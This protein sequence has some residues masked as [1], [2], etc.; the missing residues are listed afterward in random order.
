MEE[1]TIYKY[2]ATKMALMMY[3]QFYSE[4]MTALENTIKNLKGALLFTQKDTLY[5]EG[6]I[7][8]IK[9][10]C[11]R[12]EKEY[13]LAKQDIEYDMKQY[14][15]CV[16]N[17]KYEHIKFSVFEDMKKKEDLAVDMCF[18]NKKYMG[19]REYEKVLRA[20]RSIVLLLDSIAREAFNLGV[21]FRKT[22]DCSELNGN[23][24]ANVFFEE[25]EKIREKLPPFDIKG[26]ENLCLD[27]LIH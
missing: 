24:P 12:I 6:R 14:N 17:R 11:E 10:V 20:K 15:D 9:E 23:M 16:R 25:L 22:F 2:F 8:G 27:V 4:L 18:D 3:Q 26:F 7:N 19:T 1:Q 21:L 13:Q 5:L